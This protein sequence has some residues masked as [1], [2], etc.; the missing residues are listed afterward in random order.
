MSQAGT[1]I[2]DILPQLYNAAWNVDFSETSTA[3]E[4][5]ILDGCYAVGNINLLETCAAAERDISDTCNA[6]GNMNYT[7]VFAYIKSAVSASK[8]VVSN[9]CHTVRNLNRED[10]VCDRV[11]WWLVPPPVKAIPIRHL[12]FA[13]NGEQTSVVKCPSE[14]R[15]VA[16]GKIAL[17]H[18]IP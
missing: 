9:A 1:P 10:F 13:I 5:V 17:C 18:N 6:V 15:V 8:S 11:P 2:E 3:S 7:K 4:S 16:V 12:T 14:N